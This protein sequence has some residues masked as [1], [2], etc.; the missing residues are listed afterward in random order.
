MAREPIDPMDLAKMRANGVR[1][2]AIQCH[3]C[4][5]EVGAERRSP[6]QR[7]DRVIVRPEDGSHQVRDDR[8]RRSAE[9]ARE[10]TATSE[11]S[12]CGTQVPRGRRLALGQ[13][14]MST[15]RIKVSWRDGSTSWNRPLRVSSMNLE[16]F[17]RERAAR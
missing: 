6:S 1:S 14:V 5:H 17:L 12:S 7:P 2:L 13:Q 10:T 11:L 8:H 9:L 16:R 4:L 3:Q 15:W